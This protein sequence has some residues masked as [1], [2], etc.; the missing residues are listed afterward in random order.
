MR[1]EQGS[2]TAGSASLSA[3]SPQRRSPIGGLFSLR[4]SLRPS[5]RHSRPGSVL[6][7]LSSH[8]DEPVGVTSPTPGGAP[9]GAVAPAP[10]PS[11]LTGEKVA[12]HPPLAPEQGPGR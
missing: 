4:P 2:V 11:E 5:H 10:Q 7:W 3:G 6:L 9:V 12:F 1:R 8:L